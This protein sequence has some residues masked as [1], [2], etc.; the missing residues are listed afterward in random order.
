MD[1]LGLRKKIKT[2]SYLSLLSLGYTFCVTAQTS[3]QEKPNIIF[4]MSDDHAYQAISAYSKALIETPNIDQIAN[5]GA[6]LYRA[7]VNNSI[8]GP[9]RAAILTGKYSHI[10]GF[11]DNHDRF[12]GDQ[13]TLPKILRSHGYH[14][15]IVG[16]WHLKSTPQGFDYWNILPGQG[17]YYN[18]GFIKMGKDTIYSGYV[19][20]ITT[21][22]ALNWLDSGKNKPFFLMIHHK[23]PH[24]NQMPPLK[25]LNLFNDRK[26][27]YPATFFDDY[28]GRLALQRNG[29]RMADN[30]D[31]DQDSKISCDTCQESKT[32]KWNPKAYQR[33][34][35][36][37]TPD[38]RKVWDNA[39]QKEYDEYVS[40]KTKEE[41]MQWQFQRYMEDYLRCIKSV[42]DNVGRVLQYLKNSGLDKNTIV[43]YTSDQGFYLGEHGLYDKRFMYEE[44]FRT[45]MLIRY[46]EG[47]KAGEKIY[48]FV[49]NLDIAPT[50]LDYAGISIPTDM[51]GASMKSLLAGKNVSDWRD[52]VYYHYYEQSYGMTAH[53]GILTKRY[54]LIHFY[55][56]IDAW[57]L[58]DLKND[59]NEM[60]NIYKN[61]ENSDL[62]D[63]LKS[64]LKVL[65]IKY[66]DEQNF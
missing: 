30:L 13:Q 35:G 3:M 27:E 66:Q 9:S 45:P 55:D 44:S 18:P 21:D 8:C 15:A 6:L 33:E 4:I 39:Y 52:K 48:D 1:K 26:F 2:I 43:I 63:S 25:Y 23:A 62:I 28:E 12:D 37:L 11:K 41:L 49:M 24:R 17:E 56:P 47:I 42:D 50:L 34:L 29:I 54:K 58:Y 5:E 51:Q 59:P 65:Q 16:K 32:N 14:T 46:P 31:L 53:Y 36:R 60:H 7:F 64:Q 57:E 19:T 22:I 61:P 10:N 38:Q 20:D 40:I